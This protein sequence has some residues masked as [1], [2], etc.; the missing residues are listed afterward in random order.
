[1]IDLVVYLWWFF[2]PLGLFGAVVYNLG[3][4]VVAMIRAD[5]IQV[6]RSAI[7]CGL[8]VSAFVGAFWFMVS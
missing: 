1:M 5:E 8:S 6:K 3:R 4:F 7:A 2:L